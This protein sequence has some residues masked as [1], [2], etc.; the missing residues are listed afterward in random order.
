M[1]NGWHF[2]IVTKFKAKYN[3]KFWIDKINLGDS[4]FID[5]KNT[6]WKIKKFFFVD[7]I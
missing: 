6:N 3:C 5:P 2:V 4:G 1:V 7:F